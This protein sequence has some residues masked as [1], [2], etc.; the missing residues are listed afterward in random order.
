MTAT[1]GDHPSLRPTPRAMDHPEQSAL[2]H[3]HPDVDRG[4]TD[5]EPP[6]PDGPLFRII[7]DR[8]VL[9]LMVGGINT[10]VGLVL[11]LAFHEVFGNSQYLLTLLCAHI[12]SVAIAFVLYR[13][14]VFR[15]RGHVLRDAWRFETVYLASLA[16]NAGFLALGVSWLHFNAVA[17]QAVVLLFTSLWSYVG[18]QRFSFHRKESV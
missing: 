13:Y 17:V 15:V 7:K 8:R 12:G 11:F 16:W 6:A 10:V 2:H 4:T 5:G 3:F 18:H 9:F 14:V 1:V